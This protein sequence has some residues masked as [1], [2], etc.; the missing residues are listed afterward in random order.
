MLPIDEAAW[1]SFSERIMYDRCDFT[2]PAGFDRLATRLDEIDT[3]HATRGNRLFYL[4]TQP[5]QFADI[6][7]QLG[8]VGP[9]SRAPRRRLAPHRHREA[10]RPRP[11]LGEEAQP[12]GRQ[13]LPRVAGLP[14]RPLPR[15][16]DR[17]QPAGLPLRQ[18]HLRAALEPTLRR[19]RAD[20]RGRVD[21]HREPRR[22]LRGD[23]RVTRRPPEPP[24]PARQPRRDGAAGDVR[25]GRAARREGQGPARDRQS[26]GLARQ[27]RARPV[28]PGLGRRDAGAGLP[29]GAGRRPASPRRRRSSRRA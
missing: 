13:G 28:R 6:V 11:R 14:H 15:Q 18:R 26:R 4:A 25:G 9:R 2:D 21:R 22:L 3:E 16:G 23:R 29:G 17:P 20:H 24:A 1:A 27:R 19:P 10:V 12:R 8:R 7:A 5:S